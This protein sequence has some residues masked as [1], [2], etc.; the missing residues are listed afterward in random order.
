[1]RGDKKGWARTARKR[2]LKT[3]WKYCVSVIWPERSTV[4]T[5]YDCR[6]GMMRPVFERESLYRECT[7]K[8]KPFLWASLVSWRKITIALDLLSSLHPIYPHTYH[9]ILCMFI[10]SFIHSFIHFWHSTWLCNP[11]CYLLICKPRPSENCRY[12]PPCLAWLIFKCC[13]QC[14]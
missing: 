13:L 8:T 6:H 4:L 11:G 7:F 14:S 2:N 3:M 12:F 9:D 5:F 1:M 10:C